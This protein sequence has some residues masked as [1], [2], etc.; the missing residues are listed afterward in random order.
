MLQHINNLQ[1]LKKSLCD[2]FKACPCPLLRPFPDCVMTSTRTHGEPWGS[3]Q[4]AWTIC[5]GSDGF[6]P[7]CH[8]HWVSI[9]SLWASVW[10]LATH[11]TQWSSDWNLKTLIWTFRMEERIPSVEGEAKPDEV[12]SSARCLHLRS[13]AQEREKF[14]TLDQLRKSRTRQSCKHNL[15]LALNV[16]TEPASETPCSLT[17]KLL[18]L[19]DDVFVSCCT[20]TCEFFRKVLH[21]NLW[22]FFFKFPLTVLAGFPPSWKSSCLTFTVFPLNTQVV[23]DIHWLATLLGPPC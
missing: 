22:C 18:I 5:V 2:S 13:S 9:E 19:V 3:A 7:S 8:N 1:N 15:F 23:S 4:P 12:C 17:L 10:T 16:S 11:G 20:N 6:R 21:C 14:F